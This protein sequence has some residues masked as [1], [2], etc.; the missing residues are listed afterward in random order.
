[1]CFAKHFHSKYFC[2]LNQNTLC[3]AIH[4][5][6]VIT[7]V[8]TVVQIIVSTKD[9]LHPHW[10][11]PRHCRRHVGAV[12]AAM[13]ATV[14]A[15]IAT[16]AALSPPLPP[17]PLP[18]P[19]PRLLPS[20][21]PPAPFLLLFSALTLPQLSPPLPAPAV[22]AVGCRRH[23]HC[24]RSRKPLPP[25]PSAVTAASVLPLFLP[26]FSLV[27]LKILLR[28]SNILNICVSV[29]CPLQ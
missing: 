4:R 21:P 5:T 9:D 16:A 7:S 19:L 6:I 29:P 1:M 23:C 15:A 25:A 27:M 18:L 26:L 12:V 13:A 11:P 20:P 24:R 10:P 2:V 3:F 28:R 17:S 14:V 22:A 8:H